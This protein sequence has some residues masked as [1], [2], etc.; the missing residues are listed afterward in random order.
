[1]SQLTATGQTVQARAAAAL[2]QLLTEHPCAPTVAWTITPP[3]EHA[4]AAH[5][6]GH[7]A[8]L[9]NDEAARAAVTAWATILGATVK[10][11]PVALGSGS[12]TRIRASVV[13][14]G[15]SIEVWTM[16]GRTD[17]GAVAA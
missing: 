15:V 10:E 14:G 8:P 16:V 17:T 12:W 7:A 1:M 6:V 9:D 11:N 4:I 13:S 2:T 3:A 5:L